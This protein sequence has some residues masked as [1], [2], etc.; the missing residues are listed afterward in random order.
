MNKI[1]LILIG[2]AHE[3]NTENILFDKLNNLEKYKNILWLCEGEAGGRKCISLKDYKIHLLTDTLFI[4]MMLIDYDDL[5]KVTYFGKEYSDMFIE[6]I[7]ELFITI[8]NSEICDEIIHNNALLVKCIGPLKENKHIA[9]KM[10]DNIYSHLKNIPLDVLKKEM[11]II[12]DKTIKLIFEK[13]IIDPKY[14]N[15]IIDF[16]KTG[17]VCEDT[18]MTLLREELFIYKIMLYISYLIINNI[19]NGKIIVTLGLDHINKIYN[20]M[21]KYNNILKISIYT[22]N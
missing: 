6:R 3:T 18:I 16:Y 17:S 7:V 21:K 8:V 10:Y 5:M 2:T 15:C 1:S 11:R 9:Y 12:V 13:K 20:Y 4:N 22:L 14:N 19:K